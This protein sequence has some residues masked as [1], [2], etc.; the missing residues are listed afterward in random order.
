MKEVQ[1]KGNSG[2][3]E[4]SNGNATDNNLAGKASKE[5]EAQMDYDWSNDDLLGE[6]DELNQAASDFLG[7]QKGVL[8]K[9]TNAA[10]LANIGS[11]PARLGQRQLQPLRPAVIA[12]NTPQVCVDR[13][14]TK[15]GDLGPAQQQVVTPTVAVST[16]AASGPC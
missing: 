16:V 14:S 6:E 9:V 10:A 8:V 12:A 15:D 1:E 11:A 4:A 13:G 2:I 5:S 7:V 3:P